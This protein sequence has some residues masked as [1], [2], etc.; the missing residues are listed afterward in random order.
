MHNLAVQNKYENY[1]KI[2]YSVGI[3]YNKMSSR[4]GIGNYMGF[5]KS[6]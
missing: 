4:P 5:S 6:K 1:V 2:L 3:K